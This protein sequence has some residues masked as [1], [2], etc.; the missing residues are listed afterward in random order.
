MIQRKAGGGGAVVDNGLW[1]AVGDFGDSSVIATST[2]NGV[3]WTALPSDSSGGIIYGRGVGY[4]NGRLFVAGY[5]SI[6][7]IENTTSFTPVPIEVT[8]INH[9]RD[10]AYADG[11]WVVVG[12]NTHYS[13][14]NGSNWTVVGGGN[15]SGR[16]VAYGN[17][18]WV[19]VGDGSKIEYSTNGTS[20]TAA[21]SVGGIT[22]GHSVAYANSR[23]IVVGQGSPIVVSSNGTSWGAVSLADRGGITFGRGVAYGNGRWVVVG[24]GTT[25]IVT[26]I[27][28]G[29]NWFSVPVANCGGITTGFGVTYENGR[30]VVVGTGS[31]IAYSTNGTNW[32]AASSVGGIATGYGVAWKPPLGTG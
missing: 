23:W 29:I 7:Y 16:G 9:A 17:G 18:R 12:S 8:Y 4:G 26:S 2:D 22:T 3:N 27:S 6:A 20:W 24:D 28:N 13:T 30:W 10:I 19:V 11:R 1:V 25:P 31:T 15:I 5:Q 32:F 21:S 14:D